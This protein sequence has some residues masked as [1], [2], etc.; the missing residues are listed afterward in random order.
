MSVN[1]YISFS[2]Q[3]KLRASEVDLVIFCNAAVN[4]LNMR[5]VTTSLFTRTVR[6]RMTAL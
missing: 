4:V 5:E 6:V 2:E 3:D 1:T